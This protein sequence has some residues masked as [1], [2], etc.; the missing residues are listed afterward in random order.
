MPASYRRLFLLAAMV[1]SAVL[2]Q[3][4][5][6]KGAPAQP[7]PPAQA[8]QAAQPTQPPGVPPGVANITKLITPGQGLTSDDAARRAVKTSYDVQAGR[9][10]VAANQAAVSTAKYGY[11][12]KLVGLAR[13]TRLSDIGA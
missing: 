2:A 5:P 12:P 9:D 11:I 1:P 13:Y 10:D 3:K 8:A 7:P 4:P 6:G